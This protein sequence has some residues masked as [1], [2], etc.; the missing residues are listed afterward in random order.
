MDGW[1]VALLAGMVVLVLLT[2]LLGIVVRAAARTVETSQ[3]ILV[4]RE[5]VRARTEGLAELQALATRRTGPDTP[6]PGHPDGQGQE[7]DAG[8]PERKQQGSG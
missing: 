1:L 2:V 7:G 4:A 8:S 5:E 3:A 6:A